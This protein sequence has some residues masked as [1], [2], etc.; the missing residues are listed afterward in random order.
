MFNNFISPFAY[1]LSFIQEEIDKGNEVHIL[2]CNGVLESCHSNLQHNIIK[3]GRCQDRIEVF[4]SKLKIP[5]DRIHNFIKFNEVNTFLTPNFKNTEELLDF[6]YDGVQLGRGVA[7]NIMSRFRD[8]EISSEK[9][10]LLLDIQL[11]MALTSYLNA[12]LVF[13]KVKPDLVYVYNGRQ[14]ED[15]PIIQLAEKMG[16]KYISYVSGANYTKYRKFE[17]SVVHKLEAVQ[18]DIENCCN[19]DIPIKE[20]ITLGENWFKASREG[21]ELNVKTFLDK[22]VKNQLPENFDHN[23]INIAIFNSSEDEV[24]TFDDWKTPLY[25]EQNDAIKKIVSFFSNDPNLHFYL[26]VHPNLGKVKN[27]QI[28]E[29]NSFSF[30]NLTVIPPFSNV[31][32]Y[33]LMDNCSKTITFGSS[34]GVEATFWG[35]PSILYGKSYYD[36]LDVVYKPK[37]IEELAQLIY[38]ENLET[39]S[40]EDA[41][42]YGYYI[43]ENGTY[44]SNCEIID[45]KNILFNGHSLSKI[46]PSTFIKIL[47]F[48][49]DTLKWM[50]PSKNKRYYSSIKTQ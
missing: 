40:K 35:K 39:K 29:I 10:E 24:K 42:K 20:K 13:E 38:T 18:K 14:A 45:S 21:R 46:R 2:K 9:F 23:K 30:F 16:I 44:L 31:D 12:K 32:T 26:R 19:S 22:Q 34:T 7:S 8:F 33:E 49:K 6:E 17:N 15:K 1:Q 36:S 50:G 25:S 37:S 4:S 43:A 5:K 11:K 3:C 47:Y 27:K 48:L 28:T 41:I